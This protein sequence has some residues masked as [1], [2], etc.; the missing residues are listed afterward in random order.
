MKYILVVLFLIVTFVSFTQ[1]KRITVV[2]DAG[3]G[4]TDYGHIPTNKS[5]MP[6]KDVNILIANFL[7]SYIKKYLHNIDIVYTRTDDSFVSLDDRVE[8][9]NAKKADYFISVHCNAND[10]AAVHGTETHVHD[11]N[12]AKSVRLAETLEKEFATRAARK[13]RGIKDTKDREHS[14]QVLKYTTMASVLVE[15]GFLTNEREANYLNTTQGQEIVASAIFR[16]FRTFIVKEHPTIDFLNPPSEGDYAVQIMSSKAPI[17]TG[18][19][20]FK[21]L[22]YEV[23]RQE[24]ESTNAYKYRYLV[25]SFKSRAD[26]KDVLKYLQENGFK[27]AIIINTKD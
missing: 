6:E 10:K 5:L 16:G 13:S 4:G 12:S 18:N 2:I 26:G 25:G 14:L 7:G 20:A 23:T 3:H 9:A 1:Q 17:A 15:C 11:I 21:Y 8:L 27:D 24:V 22:K 19:K